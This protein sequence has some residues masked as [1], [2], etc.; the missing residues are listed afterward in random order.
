M[1]SGVVDL[2]AVKRLSLGRANGHS[3][4][5][6]TIATSMRLLPWTYIAIQ[7]RHFILY[8]VQTRRIRSKTY[9]NTLDQLLA[10]VVVRV[11]V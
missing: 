7:P 11:F 8:F 3:F 5:A 2:V 10:D 4:A 1:R 9:T 6:A